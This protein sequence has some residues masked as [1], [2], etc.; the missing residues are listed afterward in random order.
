MIIV[1]KGKLPEG[2][3]SFKCEF[4]G[5]MFIA[6]KDEYETFPI[7]YNEVDYKCDCPTCGSEC[8]VTH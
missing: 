2:S 6:N 5:C 7:Q 4:C 3:I 8:T 1:K